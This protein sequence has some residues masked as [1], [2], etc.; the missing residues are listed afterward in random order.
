MGGRKGTG[1][2]K[3][4]GKAQIAVRIH[5]DLSDASDESNDEVALEPAGRK[6]VRDRKATG[7]L[8]P[9][10]VPKDEDEL[11]TDT[12]D[13]MGSETSQPELRPMENKRSHIWHSAS[14]ML[15]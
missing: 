13:H 3:D 5:H 9:S 4:L 6:R 1:A 2:P 7:F 10:Q 12:S 11:S 15:S 14:S 8:K